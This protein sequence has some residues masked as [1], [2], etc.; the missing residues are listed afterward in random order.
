MT[1]IAELPDEIR[2]Y[3]ARLIEEDRD[4]NRDHIDWLATV[5]TTAAVGPLQVRR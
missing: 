5:K 4:A 3:L 1:L 2:H